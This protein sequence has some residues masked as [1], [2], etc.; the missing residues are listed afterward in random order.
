MRPLKVKDENMS[1]SAKGYLHSAGINIASTISCKNVCENYV[2]INLIRF[3]SFKK[4]LLGEGG[5]LFKIE[6]GITFWRILG[7]R[8]ENEAE[9]VKRDGFY[10]KKSLKKITEDVPFDILSGEKNNDKNEVDGNQGLDVIKMISSGKK[11]WYEKCLKERKHYW[12]AKMDFWNDIENYTWKELFYGDKT[13][14]IDKL[15]KEKMRDAWFNYITKQM[16]TEDVR[17]TKHFKKMLEKGKSPTEIR[18]TFIKKAR[19]FVQKKKK[20]MYAGDKFLTA[21]LDEWVEEKNTRERLKR[22]KMRSF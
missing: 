9:K 1:L 18:D 17:D 2:K 21:H 5:T 6:K 7:E 13:K 12:L 11:D 22:E 15:W 16:W 10:L 14:D 20:I 8:N 4:F 3:K 19:T